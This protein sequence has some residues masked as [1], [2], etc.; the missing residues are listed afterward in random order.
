MADPSDWDNEHLNS[1]QSRNSSSVATTTS[2]AASPFFTA[3]TPPA[4][5]SSDPTG[6]YWGLS[7]TCELCETSTRRAMMAP[8][9]AMK[10]EKEKS[11]H[12]WWEA[13][14]QS[15]RASKASKASGR[16]WTWE[17]ERM[18]PAAKHLM[19]RRALL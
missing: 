14:W 10:P 1:S 17:V 11:F 4:P 9:M 2:T 19:K 15:A 18:M 3:T 16:M 7:S 8:T 13:I 6:A 12:G 5:P